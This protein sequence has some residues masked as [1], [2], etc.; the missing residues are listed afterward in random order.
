LREESEPGAPT[1][2]EADAARYDFPIMAEIFVIGSA[3]GFPAPGRGHSSL[4]LS[5]SDRS[6]LI[7]AGEPCSR[8]LAEAGIPFGAIDAVLLTHGH[9][10]HTGG[11]PMLI[12]SLW[13]SQRARPLTIFLPEELIQPLQRW[14]NAIYL[15]SDFIPFELKFAAWETAQSFEVSGLQISPRET[16]H[17]QSLSQK[18]G[19]GRFKAYSLQIEHSDFRI[20]F[21]GDL[22]SP[23]DLAVQLTHPVDLLV[24]ELAHFPP[25]ELFRFLEPC[26]VGKLLL[27]HLASELRGSEESIV[28]EAKNV[29]PGTAVLVAN[30]GLRVPV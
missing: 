19:N 4:L 9:A 21:S 6:I 14:L 15:G 20:V 18:F 26:K 11:L 5:L 8:S 17:L 22:G 1:V 25:S 27:T 28:R 2:V 16:T 3:S 24:S 12:Q 7:D 13:L 23:T 29:L 30:D 10:D